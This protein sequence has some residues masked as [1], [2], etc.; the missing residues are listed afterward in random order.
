MSILVICRSARRPTGICVHVRAPALSG[1][2]NLVMRLFLSSP[3]GSPVRSPSYLR[4]NLREET[5]KVVARLLLDGVLEIEH[6]GSFCSGAAARDVVL[7]PNTERPLGVLARLSIEALVYGQALEGLSVNELAL[8]LYSYGRRP[9]SPAWQNKLPSE[10]AVKEYLGLGRDGPVQAALN[11]TWLENLG[12]QRFWR[13]WRPRRDKAPSDNGGYKLY[14]SAECGALP[15]V[16][17]GTIQTLSGI[18]SVEGFKI[19]RDVY[20][21]C[22]PDK[23]VAYFSRLE[24]LQVAASQLSERLQGSPAH[25]ARL[26]RRRRATVCYRGAST[27][28]PGNPLLN[29]AGVGDPG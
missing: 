10:E 13:M 28:R 12:T 21:L 27:L 29:L 9:V 6:N 11:E 23:L 4:T 8:R 18:P 14:V 1:D 22:R 3:S 25:G 17:L 15:E 2:L 26:R 5:G 24:D 7:L 16:F 20:G 19:G